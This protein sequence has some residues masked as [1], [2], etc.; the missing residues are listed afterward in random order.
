MDT[1][2]PPSQVH[3]QSL[4]ATALTNAYG[5]YVSPPISSGVTSAYQKRRFHTQNRP[6]AEAGLSLEIRDSV[7]EIAWQGHQWQVSKIFPWVSTERLT[8]SLKYSETL[9][10][11]FSVTPE[12]TVGHMMTQ[13]ETTQRVTL[14]R[15]SLQA[16]L[17][18][19]FMNTPEGQR[20]YNATLRQFATS[21]IETAN[22]EVHRALLQAHDP[23]Q[24]WLQAHAN[25]DIESLMDYMNWDHFIFGAL[26]KIRLN[27]LQKIDARIVN[28]MRSYK[29]IA[30]SYVLP[31]NLELYAANVPVQ[32][33][34]YSQG[35]QS[36]VN[37][38]R[39]VGGNNGDSNG[40]SPLNNV[41]PHFMVGR[42][43][44]Y[45]AR[46]FMV[47]DQGDID[48]FTRTRQFGEW[49]M[50]QDNVVDG[51]Y[52]SDRRTI[53]VYDQTKDLITPI[54]LRCALNACELFDSSD[55]GRLLP[56]EG[57]GIEDPFMTEDGPIAFIGDLDQ[58]Y[59]PIS[60]VKRAVD[61]IVSAMGGDD[62]HA[63]TYKDFVSYLGKSESGIAGLSNDGKMKSNRFW[64]ALKGFFPGSIFLGANAT[65]FRKRYVGNQTRDLPL[66]DE[67][68]NAVDGNTA[69]YTGKQARND[70]NSLV[71]II[72][73]SFK[74]NLPSGINIDDIVDV[75]KNGEKDQPALDVLFEAV[76]KLL[77]QPSNM[78]NTS[79]SIDT[80]AEAKKYLK[81]MRI[82]ITEGH[83][84]INRQVLDA[85]DA[86]VDDD[87]NNNA[88]VRTSGGSVLAAKIFSQVPFMQDLMKMGEQQE[89]AHQSQSTRSTH[90][91]AT[92]NSFAFD[93]ISCRMTTDANLETVQMNYDHIPHQLLKSE[94]FLLNN[95]DL[96]VRF[97][98]MGVN[99]DAI[100]A[101]SWSPIKKLIAH[102][103]MGV[104]FTRKALHNIIDSNIV[105]PINF[106][107]NRPHAEV[108]SSIMIK[109]QGGGGA[110][111][112]YFG[113]TNVATG[114]N[115][116][117]KTHVI[118]MTVYLR[119]FA[120]HPKNIF[121]V[122]DVYISGYHGGL[123]IDFFSRDNYDPANMTLDSP[124]ILCFAVDYNTTANTLP[125]PI[126]LTGQWP[127]RY[128]YRNNTARKSHFPTARRYNKIYDT[129]SRPG[130]S[131]P[132]LNEIHINTC[133]WRGHTEE[134]DGRGGL[135]IRP[136]TGV[137]G[138]DV[139]EGVKKI[140]EGGLYE[141]KDCHYETRGGGS[142]APT[143]VR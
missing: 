50:M 78:K 114:D 133:M 45:I 52:N 140:R 103:Y 9:P 54:D 18:W 62:G 95:D 10:T 136:N 15:Y 124:S 142:M 76:R 131:Q 61:S 8:L 2:L 37:K 137:W 59:L 33:I 26:Q 104:P 11:F 73:A 35:G 67:Q 65:D 112:T 106:L 92:L 84:K 68:G 96:R 135:R 105:F 1:L 129:T 3:Q 77:V 38:T 138:S 7:E 143:R 94:A 44:V 109:V 19:G 53:F 14:V 119:A 47:E 117:L 12:Q 23:Q 30:D 42:N 115:V 72:I 25:L 66:I 141:M 48:P 110:G 127:S 100:E 93:E 64:N 71:D 107:L 87:N 80:A 99:F 56:N 116:L 113:N 6:D 55:E 28:K 49:N 83:E 70:R 21:F 81:R 102:I 32:G 22:A 41:E 34:I 5:S 89:Q 17:E 120:H 58:E 126:D 125:N 29:G 121:I 108:E 16:R 31:E 75:Y 132:A 69:R 74:K 134:D 46:S 60:A 79:T 24:M 111:N 85:V 40:P 43:K 118:N 39:G 98:T 130:N 128:R 63:K 86:A 97:S 57:G 122:P 139:Y 91:D 27:P 101:T 123:G 82:A 36:A 88:D 90:I 4:A 13:T 20:K 51:E